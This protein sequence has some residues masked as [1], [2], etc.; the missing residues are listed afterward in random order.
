MLTRGS[1][2]NAL[3][4]LSNDLARQLRVDAGNHDSWY[5]IAGTQFV[6][7]TR[8][9]HRR[10]QMPAVVFTRLAELVVILAR[11][12]G[13]FNQERRITLPTVIHAIS[14]ARTDRPYFSQARLVGLGW[15]AARRLL[16]TLTGRCDASQGILPADRATTHA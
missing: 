2:V 7:A 12:T 6:G 8:L 9:F 14:T 16:Q 1:V 3:G 13:R 15:V 11:I 5:H 4:D 10:V